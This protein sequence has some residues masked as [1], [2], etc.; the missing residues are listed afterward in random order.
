MNV[1]PGSVVDCSLKG[2]N[3]IKDKV[4]GLRMEDLS[5]NG[6]KG[7]I[8]DRRSSIVIEN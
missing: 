3:L 4:A 7:G 8:F 1:G 2:E 6:L 5:T